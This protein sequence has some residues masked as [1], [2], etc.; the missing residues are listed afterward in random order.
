MQIRRSDTQARAIACRE[1]ALKI[2]FLGVV[3]LLTSACANQTSIFRKTDTPPGQMEIM[4]IDAKQRPI[5]VNRVTNPNLPKVCVDK[6][7]DALSQLAASGNLSIKQASGGE[8]SLGVAMSEQIQSI[9]FRTQ[10][11]ETQQ[12]FMF[13][14]CQLNANGALTDDEVSENTRH[15]QNTLLAMLAVEQLT[16]VARSNSAGAPPPAN[17]G[18]EKPQTPDDPKATDVK[19]KQKSADE[20]KSAVTKANDEVSG[21]VKKVTDA[22]APSDAKG[23][24]DALTKALKDYDA[25]ERAYAKA[26]GDLKKSISALQTGG[27]APDAVTSSQTKADTAA[28]GVSAPLKKVNDSLKSVT[29]AK[30]AGTLKIAQTDLNAKFSDYQTADKTY[31]DALDSL[32]QAQ[33]D[34]GKTAMGGGADAK[35]T[36][37]SSGDTPTNQVAAVAFAVSNIVQTIVWQSFITETCLKVLFPTAKDNGNVGDSRPVDDEAKQYCLDHLKLADIF[38]FAQIGIG[39]DSEGK[40]KAID[41][42]VPLIMP[43]QPLGTFTFR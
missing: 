19:A 2:V 11:T 42:K 41:F 39:I 25:K 24:S 23:P 15:F 34:W 13:Y 10:V 26:L 18:T 37:K 40:L 16:G 12:A 32:G 36:A 43:S 14:V 27:T 7:P 38:R 31:L 29:Q 5:T 6:S 1:K 21:D 20:A 8:G 28:K 33:T 17:T 35:G 4:Q 30:D 3:C 22:T 9:A